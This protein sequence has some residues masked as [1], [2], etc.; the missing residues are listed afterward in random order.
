MAR[1]RGSSCPNPETS[2]NKL[3]KTLKLEDLDLRPATQLYG[4]TRRES[5]PR[6]GA[7]RLSPPDR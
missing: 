4:D 6:M 7:T 2:P 1:G 5:M 3:E